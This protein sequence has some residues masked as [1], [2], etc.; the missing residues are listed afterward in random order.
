VRVTMS[1]IY[2]SIQSNLQRLAED[3]QM[4]NASMASGKKYQS[5]ND[6]PVDVGAILGLTQE[7]SQMVQYDRNLDTAKSWLSTTL[8]ALQ[9]ITDMVQTSMAL[10]NQMATGTYNA[11]QRQAAAQQ[12]QGCIEEIMQVGNTELEGQHILA[13]YSTDSPPFVEG[14]WAVQ[15]PVMYLQSGST[16]TAMPGGTYTGDASRTYLVEVVSGGGTGVGT[17]RVSVNGGQTWTTPAVIPAGPVALGDGVEVTMGGT[18]VAGDIFSISVY[19]PIEYQGDTHDIEI[20]IGSQSRLVVNEIGS[21][22]IGGDLGSN[23]LFQIL[24]QLKGSLEANDSEEVGASLERLRAYESHITSI[25]AG[26]GA[27]LDRV[28]MKENISGYLKDELTKQISD[29]GDTDLV[30]AANLLSAKETAYQAALL[31]S[32]KVMEMSLMDYL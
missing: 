6:S 30:A 16:G 7:E 25:L 8:S 23:D 10:A 15:S 5:I 12:I 20:A 2:T 21:E 18:W 1:T 4:I 14:A 9:N 32:S 13:G 26:L 27:S 3:L 28:A 11:S 17:Y 22:A 31:S 24:A 19:R 29:R